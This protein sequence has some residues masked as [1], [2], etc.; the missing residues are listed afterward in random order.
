LDFV[1]KT[2][3]QIKEKFNEDMQQVIEQEKV[4]SAAI[5]DTVKNYPE[6]ESYAATGSARAWMSAA[7]VDYS[8][9]LEEEEDTE[10]DAEE[11]QLKDQQSS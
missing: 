5:S 11:H 2:H 9:E 3:Q 8:K 7:N 10:E 1:E 4:Q 6:I